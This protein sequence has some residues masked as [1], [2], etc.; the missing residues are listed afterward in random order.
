VSRKFTLDAGSCIVH[1]GS[2]AEGERWGE[3][4]RGCG[5]WQRESAASDQW[6]VP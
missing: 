5:C 3:V 2:E 1:L 6:S 4:P